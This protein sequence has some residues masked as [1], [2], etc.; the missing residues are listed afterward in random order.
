VG[1]FALRKL[2]PTKSRLGTSSKRFWLWGSIGAT[3]TLPAYLTR[4]A[5]CR[6][7]AQ[8]FDSHRR[9]L[10]TVELRL[11]SSLVWVGE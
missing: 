6:A 10:P 7:L 2:W 4:A 3:L 1:W 5:A 11:P 8:H 9:A